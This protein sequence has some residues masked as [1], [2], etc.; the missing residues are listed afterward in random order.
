MIVSSSNSGRYCPRS[1]RALRY[2]FI[3][4]RHNCICNNNDY[5]LEIRVHSVF[6]LHFNN[7]SNSL[8][9]LIFGG[10]ERRAL[11][12]RCSKAPIRIR[13]QTNRRLLAAPATSRRRPKCRSA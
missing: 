10:S 12:G 3:Q 11:D 2:V 8:N 9:E 5:V 4:K 13:H 1:T 6:L 7:I